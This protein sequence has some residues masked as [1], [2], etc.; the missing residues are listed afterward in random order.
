MALPEATVVAS[1]S[2]RRPTEAEGRRAQGDRWRPP[3]DG[4]LVD[5]TTPDHPVGPGRDR[6]GG[7]RRRPRRQQPQ[8]GGGARP[9]RG[10]GGDRAGASVHRGHDPGR[11]GARPLRP[12]GRDAH[13]PR[14]GVRGAHRRGGPHC[15]RLRP[16][17]RRGGLGAARLG[18]ARLRAGV[19]RLLC[20]Q[21]PL[22][23]PEPGPH[24]VGHRLRPAAVLPSL[25]GRP[26]LPAYD[27]RAASGHEGA[28]HRQHPGDSPGR[29]PAG[30]RTGH[31]RLHHQDHRWPR[32]V[33]G[34]LNYH[35]VHGTV[36]QLGRPRRLRAPHP[37]GAARL[38]LRRGHPPA[39]L[40]RASP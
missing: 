39:P 36:R 25:P 17:P 9:R 31:R 10:L 30:A 14:A 2:G 13:P 18:P 1:P 4:H 32:P 19:A 22:V 33:G 34:H 23:A 37:G 6:G 27:G 11:R 15:D 26:C 28:A 21:R 40:G 24:R 7:P 35:P 29:P 38:R 8:D 3:P 16:S 20:R 12:S 5:R